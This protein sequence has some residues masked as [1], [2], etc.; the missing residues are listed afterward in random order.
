MATDDRQV[1]VTGQANAPA[2][3]TIPGNGQIKPRSLFA[4]YDGTAAT[5][6]FIPALK[7]ISDGGK[8]VGVYPSGSLVA[9]GGSADVSWFPGG[10]LDL[11]QSL[12]PSGS[13]T[14]VFFVDSLT[15]TLTFSSTVLVSGSAYTVIVEGTYTQVNHALDVGTPDA[16][17]MFPGSLA[18]RISTQVGFDA[19][20]TYAY[21]SGVSGSIGHATNFVISLDGGSSQSYRT[22][23]GGPYSTPTSGHLYKYSL[24]GQGHTVG[25]LIGDAPGAYTDNYGKLRITLQGP[26]SGGLVPAGP[27]DYQ[28][29]SALSSIPT[30]MTIDGGSA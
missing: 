2:S 26:S 12:A 24:I 11:P 17:A 30:W 5:V 23:I 7:V 15:S 1:I 10:D 27:T 6:P 20:T 9:A 18:G 19:E 29:L 4:H 3:W 22:P 8:T 28:V 21:W 14:E 16:D 25:F 13:T